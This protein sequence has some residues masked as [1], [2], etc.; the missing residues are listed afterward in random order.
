MCFVSLIASNNKSCCSITLLTFF[1]SRFNAFA[2]LPHRFF[3][4]ELVEVTEK[5]YYPFVSFKVIRSVNKSIQ[6]FYISNILNIIVFFHPLDSVTILWEVSTIRLFI[7]SWTASARSILMLTDRP[8]VSVICLSVSSSINL[9]SQYY[10]L[11]LERTYI[12]RVLRPKKSA[13]FSFFFFYY[14]L[15][16]M[17][18]LSII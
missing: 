11:T 3:T 10:Y 7:L 4:Q 5:C 8:I 14:R 17:L 13:T 2:N 1:A 16:R 6:S 12:S 15:V 9:P 18:N